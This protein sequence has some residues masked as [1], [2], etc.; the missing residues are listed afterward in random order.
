MTVADTSSVESTSPKNSN[1]LRVLMIAYA[2]SPTLGSEYRHAWELSRE[3]S[4]H[5]DLT[6]L[7]GDSDGRMGSFDSYDRY[8][9]ANM[10]PVHATKVEV[11]A[12]EKAIARL[13]LRMPF[14]LLFA[15]LLR[16]WHMRAF[17]A[18]Q[19]L[20]SDYPFDVVHQL[21]PIG[22][23]NPGYCWKLDANT[24]WG[25]VGGAQ[26][27]KL[28]LIRRRM[29]LYFIEALIR[30]L[31]V[32]LK[33]LSPYVRN[34]AHRF[35]N[36]SFATP[37]N[38]DYFMRHFGRD[39]MVIS[40]QGLHNAKNP[41]SQRNA[42]ASPLIV[43]WG[44]TLN[45]RKNVD[46][47]IEIAWAAPP[48][49]QF[50]VMGDGPQRGLLERA[51]SSNPRLKLLGHLSRSAVHEAMREADV[52]LLTSLSEANTAIIFEGM[53]NGCIPAAPLINGFAA[54]LNERFAVT[55]PM[56]TWDETVGHAVEGLAELLRPGVLDRKRE[57]LKE[58]L[59]D[60]TWKAL[61]QKHMKHYG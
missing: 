36:V 35:D 1:R 19:A 56:E 31:D 23:R 27:I 13:M 52:I 30:N 3:L 11:S 60:L 8:L 38:R 54:C 4:K 16:L 47:L 55:Y 28:K 15:F 18:A 61:A 46:L 9:A 24:Y 50:R 42:Q 33:K 45:N 6:L 2:Y 26:Y 21:G 37:E 40:D 29:S 12:V 5:H 57:N 39:G 22:F 58:A 32:W 48:E 41:I 49:I 14:S 53:E 25:P 7:F 59:A 34:A 43:V 51:A 44:G 10:D 20:H 17:K